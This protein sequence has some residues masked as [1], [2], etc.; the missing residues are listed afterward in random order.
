MVRAV[1][2]FNIAVPYLVKVAKPC[3]SLREETE[4]DGAM[5]QALPAAPPQ[6]PEVPATRSA[7]KSESKRKGKPVTPESVAVLSLFLG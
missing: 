1:H 2:L 5:A 3:Y 7:T 6:E 4:G